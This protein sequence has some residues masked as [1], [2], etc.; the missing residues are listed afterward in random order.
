MSREE[1]VIAAA[2][3]GI[4]LFWKSLETLIAIACIVAAVFAFADENQQPRTKPS[5]AD[6]VATCGD[7]TPFEDLDSCGARP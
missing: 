4:A 5:T 7:F 3:L 1:L 2:V 6:P